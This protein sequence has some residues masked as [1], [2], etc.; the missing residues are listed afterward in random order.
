[1]I[2]EHEL[3]GQEHQ[4]ASGDAIR[5][6]WAMD[7]GLD[8]C[9]ALQHIL[10]ATAKHILLA[11]AKHTARGQAQTKPGGLLMVLAGGRHMEGNQGGNRIEAS[12]TNLEGAHEWST[13]ESRG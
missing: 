7:F 3:Q 13:G 2:V 10:L 11:T 9:V 12:G 8:Q 4:M 1:M 6:T 5:E